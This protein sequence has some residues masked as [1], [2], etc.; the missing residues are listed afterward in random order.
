MCLTIPSKLEQVIQGGMATSG[1]VIRVN[2]VK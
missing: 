2:N 1:C